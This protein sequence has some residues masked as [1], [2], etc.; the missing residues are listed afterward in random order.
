MHELSP[1]PALPQ[2]CP[3]GC[4]RGSLSR[5]RFIAGSVAAMMAI[6]ARG[7][8]ATQPELPVVDIH[9]HCTHRERP[10]AD[11][12]VH[13][14]NTGVQTTVLLPAGE[15]GGLAAGAAGNDYVIAFARKNPGK[16]VWFANENVF[17]PEAPRVIARYLKQGA[18]GIGELKDKVAC[19]SPEMQRVAEVARDHGVPMLIHFQDGGYNDGYARFHRMLEKFP[20]VKFIGHATA[21]WG[22]IDRNYEPSHQQ[23][24]PPGRVVP[25]GLTDRWLADYPNL[26][27]DLSAG[28]GNRALA[29]DAEF[30]RGFLT[31]H[32][33]K[34]MYG[35]DCY[36]A[37]G[38]GPQCLGAVK[39]G[40]LQQLCA[41]EE[42]R[43][44]ILAG[45]ARRLLKLP[46]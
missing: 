24:P 18:I 37:T 36:C 4:G 27:G 8:T 22:G 13:Q 30:T 10:D 19:D 6:R 25:G 28:S 29:R 44:K 33:D 14:R 32:Q 3:C 46:A 41:T 40:L 39:L 21:F 9:V 16:F 43:R 34:L 38:I 2:N 5:R 12:L 7:A 15:T 1:P 23:K 31:R 11:V 20:T 26:Y 45:N 17:R 42:I 35:S